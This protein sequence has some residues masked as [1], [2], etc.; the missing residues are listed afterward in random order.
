MKNPV[1]ENCAGFFYLIH[2]SRAI[3]SR[4]N[5]NIDFECLIQHSFFILYPIVQE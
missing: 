4:G 1:R 5:N 2:T 3:E